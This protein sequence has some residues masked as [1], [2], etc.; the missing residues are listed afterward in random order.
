MRLAILCGAAIFLAAAGAQQPA[1]SLA[2]RYGYEVVPSKYPQKT[3][4][5]ALR[6]IVQAIEGKRIDYLMAQ[7]ADPVFVDKKVAE[8]RSQLTGAEQARTV[9]AFDR[10]VKETAKYFQDDPILAQ[11]LKR[12][13]ME[14]EWKMDQAGAVCTTKAIP[15][16]QIFMRKVQ[17]RWFLENKQK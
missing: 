9:L 14:G 5:E 11:E 7:L 16:R 15:A 10:L 12:F 13:A 2:T 1:D 4:E 17:N 8:Y 3:P 6:S